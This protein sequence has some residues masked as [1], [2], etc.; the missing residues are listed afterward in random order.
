M[1][2]ICGNTGRDLRLDQRQCVIGAEELE[3]TIVH[4]E[5]PVDLCPARHEKDSSNSEPLNQEEQ[6]WW[7][8]RPCRRGEELERRSPD[9]ARGVRC[10]VRSFQAKARRT[11]QG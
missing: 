7:K 9:W 11:R 2:A 1:F 6:G 8:D 4:R 10:H 3:R 5:Q